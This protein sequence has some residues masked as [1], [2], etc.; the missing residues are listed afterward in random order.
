MQQIYRK[1]P[2]RSTISIELL[3]NFIEITLQRRCSPINLLHIF[4]K[5][6][7][8]NTS[9]WLLLYNDR[10]FFL[11]INWILRVVLASLKGNRKKFP[12]NSKLTSYAEN[13]LFY[14]KTC[15]QKKNLTFCNYDAIFED[16]VLFK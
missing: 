14:H 16:H 10:Y 4:R 8:K 13:F 7:L 9:R 15:F 3:C 5:T 11:L 12:K 1:H 2:C 6:F